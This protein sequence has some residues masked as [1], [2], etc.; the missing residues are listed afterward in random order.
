MCPSKVVPLILLLFVGRLMGSVRFWKKFSLVVS[1]EF[2]ESSFEDH[3]KNFENFL[4]HFIEI[5]SLTFKKGFVKPPWA[6][7]DLSVSS[8]VVERFILFKDILYFFNVSKPK[9][10][11]E[12]L[13]IIVRKY[14]EKIVP[15]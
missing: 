8:L 11:T 2:L 4:Q 13:M 3:V 9:S 1:L 10:S 5:S 15:I 7:E 14:Y 6:S 12:I